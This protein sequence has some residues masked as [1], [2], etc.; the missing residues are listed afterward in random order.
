MARRFLLDSC[1]RHRPFIIA[2]VTSGE[3]DQSE[4]HH[5]H[6]QGEGTEVVPHAGDRKHGGL[7]QL[8]LDHRVRR[9]VGVAGL[10][11]ALRVARVMLSH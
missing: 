7:P 6:H 4:H 1:R 10:G 9:V 3:E 8:R 2:V 5:E 11:A